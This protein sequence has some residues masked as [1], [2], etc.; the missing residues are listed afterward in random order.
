MPPQLHLGLKATTA[1][2]T[3]SVANPH[4]SYKPKYYRRPLS[5]HNGWLSLRP[6]VPWYIYICIDIRPRRTPVSVF[7]SVSDPA[8]RGRFALLKWTNLRST[9]S[10]TRRFLVS[11]TREL[12]RTPNSQSLS[13]S[14]EFGWVLRANSSCGHTLILIDPS[15]P[16]Q[17][18][19]RRVGAD[20]V[21]KSK[22][23][24][25]SSKNNAYQPCS[26]TPCRHRS[27]T[28]ACIPQ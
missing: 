22:F 11:Q 8:G 15:K 3:L 9:F 16:R 24:S 23:S 1:L 18:A 28:L 25:S 21:T 7:R 19:S 2:H 12:A 26:P 14:G 13:P 10:I 27:Q 6:G 17:T 20:L 5:N 4:H